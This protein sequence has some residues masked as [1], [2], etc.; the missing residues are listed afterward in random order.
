MGRDLIWSS[1]ARV[2]LTRL[3][4][5]RHR[6]HVLILMYHAVID[7]SRPWTK[8]TH[9]QLEQFEVQLRF[10]ARHYRILP[11]SE[12]ARAMRDGEELPPHT[13]AITFD[14]G[15]RNNYDV[16]WPVLRALDVPAT[17]YLATGFLDSGTPN[18]PDRIFR[19]EEHTSELQSQR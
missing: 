9:L 18:W 2:G 16:A 13:A 5:A 7:G 1:A 11:L 4:R 3:S 12:V 6:E 10:V 15:Y 17:I 14:D 19:S 8:W